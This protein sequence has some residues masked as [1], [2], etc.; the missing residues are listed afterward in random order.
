MHSKNSPRSLRLRYVGH[1]LRAGRIDKK[2]ERCRSGHGFVQQL[3][4]FAANAVVR[5]LTP[6][7]LPPGRL[8]LATRPS[9]IGSPPVAN[10]IGIVAVA[11][12][13]NSADAVLPGQQSQR[14]RDA[15]DL[16]PSPVTDRTDYPPIDTK[17]RRYTY[18]RSPGRRDLARMRRYRA[19][20]GFPFRD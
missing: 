12:F 3:N 4:S 15:R 7:R 14:R 16:R 2:T 5:K 10:T 8:K 11:A 9:L 18:Q 19:G 1:S 13:A 17:F 6:V 20:L